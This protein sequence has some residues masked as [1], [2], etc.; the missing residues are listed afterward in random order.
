MSQNS[1]RH[2]N[3]PA[4]H[5]AGVPGTEE[6]YSL[7][8]LGSHTGDDADHG[9]AWQEQALSNLRPSAASREDVLTRAW[10]EGQ[11]G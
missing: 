10:S 2:L 3:W 7:L 4:A 6:A 9:G 11:T 5:A 8:G 1:Q